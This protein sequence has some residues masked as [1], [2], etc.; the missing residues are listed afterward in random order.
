MT[1]RTGRSYRWLFWCLALTGLVLDQASK[2]AV[3]TWLYNDGRGD[4]R[5]IIP[6]EGTPGAFYLDAH[7][8]DKKEP[9]EGLLGTLRTLGGEY[10]PQ[11]NQGALWGLGSGLNTF[12]ASVSIGA[13]LAIIIWSCRPAAA[14]E[15]FLCV[16]LGLIL[17]GTLGNFYDR[18]VFGGVRDFLHWHYPMEDWGNFPVFNLAD[19]FLVFGASLLLLQAFFLPPVGE[20]QPAPSQAAATA[21]QQVAEVPSSN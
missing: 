1:T 21:E 9:T 3:F 17:G 15:R 16:A 11:V 20:K 6:N 14:R 5:T 18:I 7:F 13:A 2:Y 12:F 19:C 4:T 8:T 10:L